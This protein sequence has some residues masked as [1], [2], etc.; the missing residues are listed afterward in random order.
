MKEYSKTLK[1]P[2]NEIKRLLADHYQ[3]LSANGDVRV[4]D[5]DIFDNEA[6]IYYNEVEIPF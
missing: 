1:V 3:E 5:V 4:V 2:I 6:I